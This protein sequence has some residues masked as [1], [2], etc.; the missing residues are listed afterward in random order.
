MEKVDNFK[1]YVFVIE[2]SNT[3]YRIVFPFRKSNHRLIACLA[4]VE[5]IYSKN[6]PNSKI[7]IK[8]LHI[9]KRTSNIRESS[10]FCINTTSINISLSN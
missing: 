3:D 9:S 2:N 10:R 6:M 4:K 1:S 5:I 8:W 7:F